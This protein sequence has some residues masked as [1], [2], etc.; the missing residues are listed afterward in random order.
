MTTRA[1]A[2]DREPRSVVVRPGHDES[3]SIPLR[4]RISG[5]AG[6]SVAR[7]PARSVGAGRELVGLGMV[8]GLLISLGAWVLAARLAEQSLAEARRL[9]DADRFSEARR[10]PRAVGR[11]GQIA[12]RRTIASVSA[13]TPA[14]TSRPLSRPGHRSIRA[15]AGRL[16]PGWRAHR[17]L[18]GDLGRFSD[19]ETIL[20]AL[21]RKAGSQHDEVRHTLSE[22]Y[23]WEG[24]RD[25][26]RR[27]IEQT[28]ASAADPKLELRDHWRSRELRRSFSKRFARKSTGPCVWRPMTTGCGWR[29][30]S[31]AMQAGRFDEAA[32][33][34]DRCCE[35]RPD[36]PD[37]WRARLNLARAAENLAEVRR[38]L[39]HLQA[40]LF[41][42]DRAL[43]LRAWL[44]SRVGNT[45]AERRALE[46]LMPIVHDSWAM[47]RLA[48]LAWNAGQADRARTIAAARRNSTQ[49]RI[50]TGF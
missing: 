8:L 12:P 39:G 11:H 25:A 34:L 29:R 28:G 26:I 24:R 23:F 14:E 17:T 37:V 9:M 49:P 40:N 45:D 30:A 36:D 43:S 10:H 20:V 44:A 15:R 38:A 6:R 48:L 7:C 19:G 35:R 16:G 18:V 3:E 27:L 13:S 46:Q 50:A 5:D 4:E 21:L 41:T 32:S 33:L 22:L 31:L 42:E 1:S 2:E 47:D